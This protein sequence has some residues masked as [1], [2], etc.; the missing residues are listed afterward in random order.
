VE[1]HILTLAELDKLPDGL[2]IGPSGLGV[3]DPGREELVRCEARGA[4]GAIEH[5]R[6][7]W[8]GDVATDGLEGVEIGQRVG[9]NHLR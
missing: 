8:C 9:H 1:F 2:G 6:E 4:A 3:R 7:R 5:R